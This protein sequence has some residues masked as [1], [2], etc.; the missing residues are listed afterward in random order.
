[1]RCYAI[2]GKG[3]DGKEIQCPNEQEGAFCSPEHH[4][5]W[6]KANPRIGQ[7]EKKNY[8]IEYMQRRLKEMAE[9]SR[10]TAQGGKLFKDDPYVE[11]KRSERR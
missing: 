2:T 8:T 3:Q 10:R 11:K 9:E 7:G 4:E 5:M 1:M 6:K